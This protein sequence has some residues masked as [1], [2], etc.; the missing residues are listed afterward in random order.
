MITEHASPNCNAR[1][2]ERGQHPVIDTL[3]I[4]Y[5]GMVPTWRARNW[6]CSPE[7]QVSAHYLLDEDGTVW[8][9]VDEADRAWHAGVGAWRGWHDLNSRSIGIEVSNPGHDYGYRPFPDRQI[10]ALIELC[11]GVLD[12]HPIPPRNVIG[13]SD[14]APA[15]KIDPGELF[16]WREL[17][18][19]GVG[20]WTDNLGEPVPVPDVASTLDAIGYDTA[21]NDLATVISAFQRRFRPANFDGEADEETRARL[22]AIHTLVA[23][24]P[25]SA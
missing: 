10:A 6:L 22:A 13:H 17:A 7:S 12:R 25:A 5:T 9:L 16:P 4:H 21:G 19:A 8:R 3:V 15:R 23:E 2:A 11:R 20:L 18:E 1:K 24:S 14:L